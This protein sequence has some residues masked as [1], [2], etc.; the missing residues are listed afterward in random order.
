RDEKSGFKTT[1]RN[2]IELRV[3]DKVTVNLQMEVGQVTETVTVSGAAP[4]LEETTSSRGETIDN[5]RVTQLPLNGRNPVNFTNLTPGVIFNG[6]PQFTR[7]FDNGDNINFSINGG[8]QQ[9]N[10]FLLD[11]QPDNAIT[12]TTTDRTRA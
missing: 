10:N 11:G 2:D 8:L 7:P 5:V 1:T 6:N 12:D 9:T 3:A 4:L